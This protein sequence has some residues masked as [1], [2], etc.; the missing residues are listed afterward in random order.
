MKKNSINVERLNER[1]NF[2]VKYAK[3]L[4]KNLAEHS[5][6]TI[7]DCI[8][9][10][11]DNGKEATSNV[12]RVEVG[13]AAPNMPEGV[14]LLISDNGCGMN[15]EELEEMF[16]VCG[17][18]DET[19]P[20]IHAKLGGRMAISKLCTCMKDNKNPAY[21]VMVTKKEGYPAVKV[22]WDGE[23]NPTGEYI[24][25]TEKVPNGTTFAFHNV[26]VSM[27]D[28]E[29]Y[30]G[31][32]SI[33]FCKAIE[34]GLTLVVNGQE[35]APEN[36]LY[37]EFD[38][39]G[40]I[41]KIFTGETLVVGPK[42]GKTYVVKYS[43][44]D[45]SMFYSTDERR[46]NYGFMPHRWDVE[47]GKCLI[48]DREKMGAFVM[49]GDIMLVFG[50]VTS[51]YIHRI[52]HAQMNGKRLLLE[53]PDGLARQ[54][55]YQVN[56]SQGFV[57]FNRVHALRQLVND[58]TNLFNSVIQGSVTR[59]KA[60]HEREVRE[61]KDVK[62]VSGTKNEVRFAVDDNMSM[63]K[64]VFAIKDNGSNKILFNPNSSLLTGVKA[65]LKGFRIAAGVAESVYIAALEALEDTKKFQPKFSM[66]NHPRSISVSSRDQ[67]L[68][69]FKEAFENRFMMMTQQ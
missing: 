26:V 24:S 21:V 16:F 1:I 20:G 59:A 32:A 40:E 19:K 58:M 50:G 56:K 8:T 22:V 4:L 65:N 23:G 63:P 14:T 29:I 45:L 27:K 28:A 47:D 62:V 11:V 9:E 38:K 51:P 5:N 55:N 64:G 33:R 10:L 3:N 41:S 34:N 15:K 48:N 61:Y 30:K 39:E 7:Y 44:R 43:V 69:Y 31:F 42:D 36:P 60:D 68:E 12:G 54:L 49:V 67:V 17:K 37:P 13:I 35:L 66:D 53:I 18:G 52:E 46:L 6:F 57:G 25:E 2:E